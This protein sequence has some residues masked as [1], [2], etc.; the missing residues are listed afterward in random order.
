VDK[1]T[2]A[3]LDAVAGA[4]YKAVEGGASDPVLYR[5]KLEERGLVFGG[6]HV[7]LR[8]LLDLKPL[9]AYLKTVGGSDLCNS[10]LLDWSS[11]TLKD[12]REGIKILNQAGRR[13]RDDGIH[14][15]YHNHDFEFAK[16]DGGKTGM[17]L[18]IE[19]LDFSVV[20]LCL[21]VAWIFRGGEDPAAYLLK[22]KERVGYL[23]FKDFDGANW[24]ELGRGKVDFPGI[25][26]VLPQLKKVRWV[27]VEQDQTQIEPRDSVAISRKYLKE[28]FGY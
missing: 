12:Y 20:D 25:M 24:I 14:L 17:D 7:G 27:M 21:D 1:D 13:L 23:H 28:R 5:R 4:G 10:A 22:H 19:G 18:L 8:Q 26:K 3:I 15:H 11:R 9:V 2:D 6:H 16:V